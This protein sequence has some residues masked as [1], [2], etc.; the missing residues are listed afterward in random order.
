MMGSEKFVNI[1]KQLHQIPEL[2][3]QERNTHKMILEYLTKLHPTTI[4]DDLAGFGLACVFDSQRPGSCVMFRAEL[5]ALPI[6]EKNTFSYASKHL[7][8]HHACGHDGH[9][10]ILLG[11][12]SYVSTHLEEI[13]GKVIFLFQPAE[14]T[15][16][17]AKKIMQDP[18]I[19]ALK[20]TYI[21][22][23][24]NIPSYPLGSIIINKTV[25]ASA[26]QGLIV[27]FHGSSSHAGEP[28]QGINPLTEMI[29]TIQ[30]LNDVS[31]RYS[32]SHP[33]S[34]ITI[35]HVKLGERAFGTSPGEGVVMA[36]FRSRDQDIMDAMATETIGEVEKIGNSFQGSCEYEWVE[37][38]PAIQNNESCVNLITDA[39][40]QAQCEVIEMQQPF[41]WT[42]DFSYYLQ[43]YP[44][45]FFGFGAGENHVPL[46]HPQYDFPDELI[47]KGIILCRMILSIIQKRDGG[48]LL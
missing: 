45:A 16:T 8:I 37:V 28:E 23:F 1:R 5:D 17:G 24:H 12:A 6:K 14:E 15:A 43:H 11:F 36:T 47:D 18:R 22:G 42:E 13:S 35:I 31:H 4:I 20:P 39:A 21:F 25:F 26:S 9:M 19:H 33:G 46:H 38:F 48:N 3:E 7:G 2:S 34:F 30:I 40:K 32:Q 27:S 41:S 10:S 44:G 29:K